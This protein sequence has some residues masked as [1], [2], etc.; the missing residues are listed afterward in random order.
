M[1]AV[2]LTFLRMGTDLESV[3]LRASGVSLYQMLPAPLVFCALCT[4]AACAVSFWGVAWGMEN[5]RPRCWT[6]RG[7]GPSSCSRAASSIAISRV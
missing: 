4:A 2:F 5:F 3:A 6:W 7:P 1:L